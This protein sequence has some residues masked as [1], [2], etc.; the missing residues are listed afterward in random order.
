MRDLRRSQLLR[1]QRNS[2]LEAT[3]CH[4]WMSLKRVEKFRGPQ[5]LGYL[6]RL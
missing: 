5:V 6:S 3:I 2:E 1:Q 4:G